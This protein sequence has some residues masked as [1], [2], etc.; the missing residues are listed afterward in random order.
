MSEY[1]TINVEVES[2]FLTKKPH[3]YKVGDRVSL[4]DGKFHGTVMEADAYTLHYFKDGSII[5]PTYGVQIDGNDFVTQGVD[6]N[7]IDGKL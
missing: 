5:Y 6:G 3:L 4:L 1:I 7:R 2:D